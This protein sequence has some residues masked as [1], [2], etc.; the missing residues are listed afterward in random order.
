MMSSASALFDEGSPPM[1][2]GL[3]DKKAWTPSMDPAKGLTKGKNT[4]G[5]YGKRW[6]SI[7]FYSLKNGG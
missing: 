5:N 4:W 6:V 3:E 1:A 7:M 2:E